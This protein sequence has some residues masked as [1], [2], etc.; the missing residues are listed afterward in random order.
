MY[1]RI[2]LFTTA[3]LFI[4]GTTLGAGVFALPYVFSVAGWGTALF[5]FFLALA[6]VVFSHILYFRVLG[7]H[8]QRHRLLGLVHLHLGATP[9]RLAFLAIILGLVFT[10]V[11][12]LLIIPQFVLLVFSGVPFLFSVIFFWLAGS[13][14]LVL[15]LRRLVGIEMAATVFLLGVVVAVFF[16]SPQFFFSGPVFTGWNNAFFPFAPLLFALAGWTSVEPI[17]DLYRR[18]HSAEPRHF[19]VSVFFWGTFLTGVFYLLF[20]LAM[21]G[22]SETVFSP[23][24]FSGITAPGLRFLIALFGIFAILTSYLP[25]GLEIEQAVHVDLRKRRSISVLF[26]IF[27]PLF[28][29][30]AGLRDFLSV[31]E[32]VGG[33]F[34]TVQYLL[35]LLVARTALPLSYIW[36]RVIDLAVTVFAGAAIYQFWNFFIS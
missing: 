6:L 5:Y 26:V 30:F 35:I 22:L 34:L 2:K 12:Y 29:V 31:I 11:A 21:S 14:P 28:L 7:F 19:P 13:L 10:L 9:A 25:I 1:N 15:R 27:L 18:K 32:L 4:I 24:D 3:T 16:Y 20:V 17:F 8:N 23:V 36:R 33:V